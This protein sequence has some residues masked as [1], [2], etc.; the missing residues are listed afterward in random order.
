MA[1]RCEACKGKRNILGLGAI[2]RK[3][4]ECKGVGFIGI[5]KQK[6]DAAHSSDVVLPKKMGRPPKVNV[7]NDK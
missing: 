5:E 1:I 7:Y 4:P 6:H 3:C 2:L